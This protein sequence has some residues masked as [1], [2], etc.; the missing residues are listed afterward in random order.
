MKEKRRATK[1]T[2]ALSRKA[3]GKG[4]PRNFSMVAK[5]ICPPSRTGMGNRLRMARLTLMKTTNH[6]SF[7]KPIFAKTGVTFLQKHDMHFANKCFIQLQ[8]TFGEFDVL[9]FA[10]SICIFGKSARSRSPWEAGG[11]TYTKRPA[12]AKHLLK[13]N[14]A[15]WVVSFSSI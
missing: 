5:S 10:V 2:W 13:A 11:G 14:S 12:S 3:S 1:R 9:V 7:L 4:S 15:R 6:K 8:K